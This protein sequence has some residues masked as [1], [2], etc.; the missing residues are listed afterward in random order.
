MSP[1]ELRRLRDG[2]VRHSLRSFIEQSFYTLNP[3][4]EFLP[5]RHIDVMAYHLEQVAE[6]H[7]RR[8]AIALAPRHLK[9]HCVSVAFPAWLFGRD[10]TRRIIAASYNADLAETFSHSTRRIMQQD[11]Y[12]RIFPHTA[13]DPKRNSVDEFHT[14][15][16]GYRIATS[17]GGALT[18]KGGNIAIIDDPLKAG[19]AQSEASRKAARDWFQTTLPTRLDNPKTDSIVLVSQRLHVE[20]LIG[21]AIEQGGW[22]ILEIPTIAMEALSI[23][24]AEGKVWRRAP[25]NILQ[26]ER[27][28]LEELNRLRTEL[29]SANF[30][31]Q[32]QQNPAPPGGNL[33][34]LH[35]FKRYDEPPPLG[36]CEAIVQSWDTAMVPGE[37]NDWSVCTTWGIVGPRFY[38]LDVYREQVNYPDLRNAAVKLIRRYKPNLVVIESAGSGISLHQDLRRDGFD[39]VKSLSPKGDKVGRLAHQSAKIEA[40]AV[41]LPSSAPWLTTLETELAVFPKGK[42]DDQVDSLSQFLYALDW[43]PDPIRSISYYAQK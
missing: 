23:P 22:T 6:G 8:L 14:T 9:S 7:I 24:I 11:W 31:A 35:W 43:R 33:I 20:D 25:D 10:P 12:C 38:L 3:G 18:G 1:N 4:Q 17:I 15:K 39:F 30:E 42:N 41:Y 29:G 19:E 27:V 37:G 2:L 5:A 26:P 34:K 16:H 32:Y 13:I 28:G 36:Q 21:L 40:G